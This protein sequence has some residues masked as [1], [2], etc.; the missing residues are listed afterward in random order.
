M[1]KSRKELKIEY[2]DHKPIMGIYQVK[3]K[4]SGSVLIEGSL[5]VHAKWNRH[6]SELKFGSH[7]NKELQSDWN[8]DKPE[9]FE[10]SILSK[11]D[12]DDTTDVNY[13]SE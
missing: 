3:N 6:C 11:L 13:R 10:F 4:I 9:A 1:G 2:K 8:R 12:Y 7:R 5:D